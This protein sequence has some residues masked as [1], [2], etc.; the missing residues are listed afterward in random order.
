MKQS[1]KYYDQE[2]KVINTHF[3]STVKNN[4][5]NSS[6]FLLIAICI[7]LFSFTSCSESSDS[8]EVIVSNCPTKNCSDFSTQSQAQ[9]TFNSNRNCYKNLD[10]DGDG[11]AC[12][13]LPN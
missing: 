9:S 12:E 5:F 3:N 1:K 8:D 2:N 4:N 10:A 11:I 13:N 6:Y 7:M